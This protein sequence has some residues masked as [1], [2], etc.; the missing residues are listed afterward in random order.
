MSKA[1]QIFD[2]SIHIFQSKNSFFMYSSICIYIF[3]HIFPSAQKSVAKS[4]D[5]QTFV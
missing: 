2:D 4:V 5:A 1:P 3:Q